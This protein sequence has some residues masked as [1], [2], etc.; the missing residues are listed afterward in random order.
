[1]FHTTAD[2]SAL[3]PIRCGPIKAVAWFSWARPSSRHN[4][5]VEAIPVLVLNLPIP[6][7]RHQAEHKRHEPELLT[8]SAACSAFVLVLPSSRGVFHCP[9]AMG[10]TAVDLFGAIMFG[11][12]RIVFHFRHQHVSGNN[13]GSILLFPAHSARC[14]FI[15]ACRLAKSRRRPI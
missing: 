3:W 12:N 9:F 7:A 6:T 14:F 10:G 13:F 2:D 1:M 8:I 4:G 11:S 5:I 15:P